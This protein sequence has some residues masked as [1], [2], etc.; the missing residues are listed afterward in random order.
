MKVGI[1]GVG[2]IVLDVELSLEQHTHHLIAFHYTLKLSETVVTVFEAFEGSVGKSS[3][4]CH[5][6]DDDNDIED[7]KWERAIERAKFI[8]EDFDL[9]SHRNEGGA[10]RRRVESLIIILLAFS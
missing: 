7:E 8:L 1:G 4:C 9:A 3:N 10:A 2:V 6:Y 5:H